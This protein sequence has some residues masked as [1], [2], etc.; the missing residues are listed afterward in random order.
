MS[1]L[2]LALPE[3]PTHAIPFSVRLAERRRD[4][5]TR[6]PA[7][8]SDRRAHLRRGVDDLE[9]LQSVRIAQ[10]LDVT[11]VDISEGGALIEV[12]SPIKPGTNLT[13]ELSG[14]GLDA[15]VP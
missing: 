14:T 8:R 4:L 3:A 2:E 15:T 12:T 1:L 13:L 9:W 10:G 6:L 7:A 5:P 11:L